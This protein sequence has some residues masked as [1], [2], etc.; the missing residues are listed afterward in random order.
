[1]EKCY[2]K[3]G[4]VSWK[5]EL[6]GRGEIQIAFSLFKKQ[7]CTTADPAS[8]LE[9]PAVSF[10]FSSILRSHG[11]FWCCARWLPFCPCL[12]RTAIKKKKKKIICILGQLS[13]PI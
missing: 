7:K 6:G 9:G 3:E 2:F 4:R 1:M 8:S 5:G 13:K 12:S 10:I 11:S